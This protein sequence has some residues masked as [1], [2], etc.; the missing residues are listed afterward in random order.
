MHTLPLVH[1]HVLINSNFVFKL[2]NIFTCRCFIL[3][4]IINIGGRE[5][6]FEMERLTLV[7]ELSVFIKAP[8]LIACIYNIM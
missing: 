5:T 8:L 3:T 4:F 2:I 6:N 7:E 1:V